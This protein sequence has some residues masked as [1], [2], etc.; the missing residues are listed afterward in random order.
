[1]AVHDVGRAQ[2][3]QTASVAYAL[4]GTTGG[5]TITGSSMAGRDLIPGIVAAD[6]RD[7]APAHNVAI[8][9]GCR[10]DGGCNFF[11]TLR[12]YMFIQLFK[13]LCY[14]FNAV[15]FFAFFLRFI[16]SNMFF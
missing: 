14:L 13:F 5:L 6:V 3:D 9:G 12:I 11:E 15:F 4:A 2:V 10:P 8:G 16:F 1:M 7:G